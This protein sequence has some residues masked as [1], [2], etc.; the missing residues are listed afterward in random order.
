MPPVYYHEGKFPPDERLD[1]MMTPETRVLSGEECAIRQDTLG[2][3][4]YDKLRHGGVTEKLGLPE[5]ANA[6]PVE[7]WF[8]RYE[9][10]VVRQRLGDEHA[11]DRVSVRTGQSA[12]AGGVCHGYRQFRETLVCD[13]PG[14]VGGDQLAA[15]QLAEPVLGGDFPSRCSADSFLIQG[16]ENGVAHRL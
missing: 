15:R 8:V 2:F 7:Q 6:V 12:G 9:N 4:S 1:R 16:V 5:S 10:E 3:G 14:N 11:V 13:S